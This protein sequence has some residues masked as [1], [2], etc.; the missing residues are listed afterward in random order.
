MRSRWF[1]VIM[2]SFATSILFTNND[3]ALAVPSDTGRKLVLVTSS[4]SDQITLSAAEG[5]KLFLGIPIE[6]NGRLLVPLRNQTDPVLYEVFLQKTM[7]MSG[8]M[9]ER[10][11][12]TR[13]LRTKGT[14]PQAY[15]TEND[16]LKALQ[17]NPN[18]VTFMWSSQAKSIPDL[19]ILVELWH[20]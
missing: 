18:T 1:L 19:R 11:L 17:E 20:E 16:L 3:A 7:F 2:L 6:L 12:L 10:T 5:R 4:Q 14:R 13:L 15:E 9:Y 8:P